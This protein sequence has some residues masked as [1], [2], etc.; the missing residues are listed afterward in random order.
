MYSTSG[1]LDRVRL[2][3]EPEEV[4][5]LLEDAEDLDLEADEKYQP[6]YDQLFTKDYPF[7]QK[8]RKTCRRS[9]QDLMGMYPDPAPAQVDTEVVV[10]SVEPSGT[11]SEP[12]NSVTDPPVVGA[13]TENPSAQDTAAP[14]I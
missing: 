9:F 14:N 10:A 5:K 7:I 13:S 2:G 8:I 3:K 4:D 12:A 6:L 1:F 11:T